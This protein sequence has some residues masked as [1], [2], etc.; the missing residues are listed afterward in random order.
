MFGV[1]MLGTL[2]FIVAYFAIPMESQVFL[3]G[4]GKANLSNV[5]LGVS[6]ALGTARHRRRRGALGQDPHARHRGR[7]GAPPDALGRR[8]RRGFVKT[9]ITGGTE[10]QLDRRRS[11]STASAVRSACSPCRWFS[12]SPAAS[13][14]CPRTSCPRPCGRRATAS[15]ATPSTP[16]SRPPMSRS[17]RSST[18]CRS[19]SRSPTHPRGQGQG[20]RA[21]PAPRARRHQGRQGA[22]LGL[23]GHRRLLQDLRV[24]CPVGLYEQQTHHLLCPCHQSTFDVTQD[25]KVIFGPAKR[26]LPQLKIT[27]DA[28]VTWWPTH[29]SARRSARAS[30]SVDEHHRTQRHGRRPPARQRPRAR[31]PG[32]P[33]A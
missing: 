21:P 4:I 16:R 3:P 26:P 12:R 17:A 30:G 31:G 15:C 33:E 8:A 9:M 18:S 24:G 2:V 7:R 13:A 14:R 25:C 1:S 10:A 5:V 29:R 6:M 22:R 20:R 27:V 23:R 19:P 28:E 32:Q 11:S